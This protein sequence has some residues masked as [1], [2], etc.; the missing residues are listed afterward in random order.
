M[1]KRTAP[2][3]HGFKGPT[4]R[5]KVYELLKQHGVEGAQCR[6]LFGVG[7]T[8]YGDVF[9]RD[10]HEPSALKLQEIYEYFTG[11]PLIK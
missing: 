1:S 3:V 9:L 4:L 7:K 11:E 8:W 10:K 6:K 5:D 2:N